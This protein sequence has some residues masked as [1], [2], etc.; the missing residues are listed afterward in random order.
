MVFDTAVLGTVGILS[1]IVSIIVEILKNILPKSIPTKIVT[2][3]TSFIVTV[4][5]G[6][7]SLPFSILNLVYSIAGGFVV[8]Y[9]SMFG[10]DQF[11]DILSRFGGGTNG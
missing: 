2:I 1:A 4:V 6:L 10:F 9:V 7:V 8:S 3:I 11:K 5:F